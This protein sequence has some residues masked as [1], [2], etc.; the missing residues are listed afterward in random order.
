M[1]DEESLRVACGFAS[2]RGKREENEDFA[3]WVAAAKGLSALHGMTFAVADGVGGHEGGRVAAELAVRGILD[4]YYCMP[5]TLPVERAAARV[6]SALNRWMASQ[7]RA[8]ER[9]RDMATTLSVL[10]LRERSAHVVHV[11]DTR[12]YRFRDGRLVRLTEDHTRRHPDMRHVLYRAL[13]IEDEVRC[14]YSCWNVQAHDRFLL[15]SDG[16]YDVVRDPQLGSLLAQRGEPTHAAQQIVAVA[17]GQGGADNATAIVVDVLAL[18]PLQQADMERRSDGLPIGELPRSGDVIDRFRIVSTLTAGRYAHTYRAVDEESAQDVVIKF[19]NPRLREDTAMRLAFLNEAWLGTQV[20]GPYLAHAVELPATRPTR[21][22]SVQPF[23]DGVTIEDLIKSGESIGLKDGVTVAMKVCKAVYS[24]NRSGIIHR[25][26]KTDNI[27]WQPDGGVKLLDLG[28]ARVRGQTD[29]PLAQVPGTP[30]YM[31][32]E[33][34]EGEYGDEQSDVYALGVTL[35][36]MFSRG[37]F[38]YGEVEPFT[39]PRFAK[40]TS[41]AVYRPDLPSWLDLVLRK[42]VHVDTTRRYGDAMELSFGLEEGLSK[43][44]VVVLR[45]RPLYDR[46]PVLVWQVVS[47]CL[48]AALLIVSALYTHQ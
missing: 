14:D 32:P 34:F 40:F 45:K 11:G 38:P 2:E 16:V 39:R 46:N 44:D 48:A 13:G 41:V 15:C 1:A 19:P 43:A 35:Y 8:D 6:V 4:G 7:G 5:V 36:R 33:L 47:F 21:L 17:L 30:S 12:I 9:L 26:I 22:Y 10:V 31:A 42:A 28:V 29:V 37:H 3:G 20:R 18:P 24:L 25:D 27:L 23:F